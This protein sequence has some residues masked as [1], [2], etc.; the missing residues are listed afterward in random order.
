MVS[1]ELGVGFGPRATVRV[2]WRLLCAGF[3]RQSAYRAAMLGGL[4]A[5]AA[6][7]LLKVAVLF[8]TV[9]A[10]G[11][12]VAGYDV[13]RM[14]AYIW[15]SQGLFGVL[16]LNGRSE[17]AT[18]VKDGS[19]VVDFLRPLDVQAAEITV[20][21]GRALFAL[22]SRGIPMIALG[23]AIGMALPTSVAAYPLGAL[24]VLLGIVLSMASAYLV[25]VAG[26]WLVETRG[27]QVLYMVMSGFLAG[28]FVPVGL[29]PPLLRAV[30]Q[31]TPFPAMMMYPV[32]VL[33]GHTDVAGMC[34]RL[35]AQ[36]AWLFGVAMLGQILTRAGRRHLEV[37]GG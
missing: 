27:I 37:Q 18:R 25:G 24:S 15:I 11:G 35:V 19:V 13:G 12:E 22:V 6:F 21:V 23:A 2:Y 26:F 9:R 3:R 16:N 4:V 34:G 36:A 31:A 5:N 30:A 7:G 1:A 33:G 32:D 28:L 14:S 10:A 29:F 17:L 20:E 8:A